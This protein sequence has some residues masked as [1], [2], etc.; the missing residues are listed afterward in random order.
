[1]RL[2][3]TC[4]TVVA[5]ACDR[6]PVPT[7]E[8]RDDVEAL[9]AG[10]RLEHVLHHVVRNAQDATPEDG[11][12][13]VTLQRQG[14]QA[15]IEVTD[16]GRGMDAAFVRERLFKPFDTTKGA[17]GMG[18]GAFQAR[19]FARAAGGDVQVSSTPGSGTTFVI[20]LPRV[21]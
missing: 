18:I 19:E 11:T 3:E 8:V 2:A 9:L 5:R 15:T 14:S 6:R 13:R 21:E 4:R 20:R 7:L 17:K 1:M 12:V 16:T 10:E